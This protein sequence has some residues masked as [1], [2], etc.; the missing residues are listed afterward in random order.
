MFS[1]RPAD[2]PSVSQARGKNCWMRIMSLN[3][4]LMLVGC[5]RCCRLEPRNAKRPC[6][7]R[8]LLGGMPTVAPPQHQQPVVA[9]D[10]LVP[11][12]GHAVSILWLRL[13]GSAA[14]T[15]CTTVDQ[16]RTPGPDTRM[17]R[18]AVTPPGELIWHAV[19]SLGAASALSTGL[20][21][22]Y[23][24]QLIVAAWSRAVLLVNQIM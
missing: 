6:P 19:R 23:F 12:A 5:V 1:R 17:Q 13:S 22:V 15:I 16:S 3:E 11:T 9:A 8:I 7:R 2:N 24:E 14:A 18:H 20:Q 10:Q 4:R 21:T